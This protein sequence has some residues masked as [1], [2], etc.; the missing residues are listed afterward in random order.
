MVFDAIIFGVVG[1]KLKGW[2]PF[3]AGVFAVYAQNNKWFNGNG[4]KYA[5]IFTF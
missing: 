2:L 4:T 1:S 5:E 3:V